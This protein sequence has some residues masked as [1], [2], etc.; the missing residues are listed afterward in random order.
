MVKRA[1]A[2]CLFAAGFAA[3]GFF[4]RYS[5]TIT[6]KPPV[7]WM[8]GIGCWVVGFILLALTHENGARGNKKKLKK[9]ITALK[10][11]GE[12]ITINLSECEIKSNDYSEEISAVSG[13]AAEFN[14]LV[15][16]QEKSVIA[17]DVFQ[18]VI[19]YRHPYF[20]RTETFISQI[21]PIEHTTLLFKLDSQKTTTIYV[22]RAN[23]SNYY[24][25]VEF[26]F[27]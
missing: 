3:V 9:N 4:N 2:Y 19:V 16:D 6:V 25:D 8:V 13:A 26:L 27:T 18:S 1:I 7:Y 22:D 11:S 24:F 23:R 15:G 17:K 20:E 12:R 5:E 14:S 21:L 10:Q